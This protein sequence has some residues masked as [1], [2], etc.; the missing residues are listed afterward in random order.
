MADDLWTYLEI[1][2][3]EPTNNA[4]E[5]TLR[6]SVIQQKNSHGVQSRQG[7][8]CRSRLL[9]VTI[10]LRQQGL[11]IVRFLEQPWIP[12]HRGGEMP[13]LLPDR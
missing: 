4:A 2:R 11:A 6:Q 5:R 1:E 13:S 10:A 3:I 9:T 8:I 7:T 12:H